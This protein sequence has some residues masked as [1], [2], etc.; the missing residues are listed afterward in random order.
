[1]AKLSERDERLVAIIACMYGK[2]AE[3]VVNHE[4]DECYLFLGWKVNELQV[5]WIEADWLICNKIVEQ[6]CG[7]DE[8]D[9]ETNVYMLT[10]NSIAKLQEAIRNRKEKNLLE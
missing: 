10:D 8:R 7:N 6:T 9:H 2:G 5:T 3:L 1:M 4:L